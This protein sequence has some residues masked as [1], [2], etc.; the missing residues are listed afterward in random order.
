MTD[1]QRHRDCTVE[2]LR[3]GVRQRESDA[4]A[5]EEPLE[6]RLGF[7]AAG[8]REEQPIAV[9]MRTPGHDHELALGFLITEGIVRSSKDVLKIWNPAPPARGQAHSNVIRIDLQ[10]E[11]A[12]DLGALQRHF[13]TS[14]SCG[15]CGKASIDA[16]RQVPPLHD[17]DVANFRISA[18]DLSQLPTLLREQQQVFGL[19]GGLH[20]AGF[21][22]SNGFLHAVREDVGRHNAMDKLIGSAALAGE[23]GTNRHGVIVSGRSSFELV[24]KVAM[25]GAPLLAGVGAPSSLAVELAE[26]FDIGL[27]GFLRESGLNIYANAQ[28]VL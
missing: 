25:Y 16:L 9:T 26:E 17:S 24:Q 7:S 13:Y 10:P 1:V 28:I 27:I 22:D 12:V 14:S 4:V 11:V 19:T 20:A 6:I 18:E 21:F 5:V 23:L 15:V 2:K 3:D 8:K